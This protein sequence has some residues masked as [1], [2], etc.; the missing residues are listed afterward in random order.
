MKPF[1]SIV[2]PVYNVA[3]YLGECLDSLLAQTCPDWEALCVDDGSTDGSGAILDAY[4]EKDPRIQVFHQ[5]NGGVSSARN[6]ALEAVRGEWLGFLDSDDM[7]HPQLLEVCKRGSNIQRAVDVVFFRPFRETSGMAQHFTNPTMKCQSFLP[8]I[9]EW[10]FSDSLWAHFFRFS[11][12]QSAR[13]RPYSIAEDLLY[14]T[15]VGVLLRGGV[16]VDASLYYYRSREGS[17]ILSPL[18][19]R[20]VQDEFWAKNEEFRTFLA[21][22]TRIPPVVLRKKSVFLSYGIACDMSRVKVSREFQQFR[23]QCLRE[24]SRVKVLPVVFRISAF[25]VGTLRLRIVDKLL[26]EFPLA[27]KRLLWRV[28]GRGQS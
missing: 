9:A 11:V 20:K 5:A 22:Q 17:A 24:F 18:S 12:I 26:F 7:F 25:L 3:P 27:T 1:F 28:L 23:Y 16:D 19:A 15:Q 8:Q 6:R 4:A 13:F 14:M 2:I 10:Y 21:H